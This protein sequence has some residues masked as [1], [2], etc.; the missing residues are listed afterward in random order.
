[1]R[2]KNENIGEWFLLRSVGD[3]SVNILFIVR[4]NCKSLPDEF[5]GD[6]YHGEFPRLSTPS[7]INTNSRHVSDN[8][9]CP[10][11]GTEA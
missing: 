10:R 1:M 4:V 3:K 5:V 8:R 7:T 9:P 11:S 2:K 6:S